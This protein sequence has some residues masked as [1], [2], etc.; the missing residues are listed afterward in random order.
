MKLPVLMLAVPGLFALVASCASETE[1]DHPDETALFEE[2]YV[3]TSERKADDTGCSG[4]RVPDQRNFSKRVVL[5]F[6]DGPNPETTPKVLATLRRH[7]APATFF[8]NGMRVSNDATRAL[9]KEIAAD[10]NMI[11]ANHSQRH[12]NLG[13]VSADTVKR[14]FLGTDALIRDAGETPRF[15]RFPFGAANCAGAQVIRDHGQV[16][17][18]W[19]ID[20]A[21]WCYAAGG[22]VCKPSTFKYV[23]DNMRNDMKAYIMSQ[24]RASGGGILLM[25][26]I[27]ASSANA[28]DGILTALEAEG[29]T[30][31]RLDD[32]TVLPR[33]NG[34]ASMPSKFIGDAC[35]TNDDCKFTVG[36][37]TGRCHAAG[38][39]TVTCAG[40]CPDSAGKAP[41]FCMADGGRD[42]GI[43]ASKA[44][45]QNNQCALLT[46]TTKKL[47]DRYLGTS[48][49]LPAEAS[50]CAP[51]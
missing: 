30:F 37:E 27:H 14:E 6:D 31:A 34:V 40:S 35:V 23:P 26:D 41:T 36:T 51:R 8:I 25:H 49:A 1:D 17:T 11:L 20:S 44:A 22:G 16:T 50:V 45:T 47:E 9:A 24:V 32:A 10:P 19:H 3:H 2:A 28:L 15:F 46:R 4:V 13:K 5:T 38:F 48:A 7:N 33:L 12:T 42:A 21:D 18:G 29:F 43:C 39:C